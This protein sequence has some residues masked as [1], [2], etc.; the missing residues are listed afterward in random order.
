MNTEVSVD[1]ITSPVKSAIP[2]VL[3]LNKTA[4][5]LSIPS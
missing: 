5:V 1:S 4:P 3:L 2:A